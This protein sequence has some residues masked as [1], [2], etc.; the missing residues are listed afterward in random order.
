MIERKRGKFIGRNKSSAYKDL[1]WTVATAKDS[2]L[3]LKEQI[4]QTLQTIEENLNELNSNKKSIVSAQVYLANITDKQVMD[5]LWKKWI[6]DNSD[7]WP[8]RASLGVDLEG[9]ILVEITVTAIRQF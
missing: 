3:Q 9:S 2:T 1:L 8:Q 6:G 5:D 7:Y 4:K